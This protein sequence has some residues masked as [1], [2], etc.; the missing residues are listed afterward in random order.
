MFGHKISCR[1]DTTSICYS[2]S[3]R[4]IYCYG[5]MKRT[6]TL[7]RYIAYTDKAT[8]TCADDF[9][10]STAAFVFSLRNNFIHS[11]RQWNYNTPILRYRNITFLSIR[12][13]LANMLLTWNKPRTVALSPTQ[14]T[15]LPTTT[16]TN[17]QD[18]ENKGQCVNNVGQDTHHIIIY[19]YIYTVH[20]KSRENA[21][22][23]VFY[24]EQ[25]SD[26]LT[27]Y[28]TV[29]VDGVLTKKNTEWVGI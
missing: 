4:Y 29:R 10:G 9:V 15:I 12:R 7:L 22:T 23:L 28:R 13:L 6:P 1:T 25:L 14:N 26:K 19:S 3:G 20:N 2:G 8:P 18:T 11:H 24:T 17:S 5:R 21:L 27:D 16:T